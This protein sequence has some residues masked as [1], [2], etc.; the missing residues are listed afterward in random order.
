M[1][2]ICE[3]PKNHKPIGKHIYSDNEHFHF[4]CGL[5][6][7]DVESSTDIENARPSIFDSVYV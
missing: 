7:Q 5:E 6:K 4:V 1:L 2:L 3:S